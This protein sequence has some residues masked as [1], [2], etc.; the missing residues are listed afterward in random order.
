[1]TPPRTPARR[2]S[3]AALACTIAWC[4]AG[5]A[6]PQA[7]GPGP[8]PDETLPAAV[9]QA[10]LQAG[11]APDSLGAIAL[12]L[13]HAGR[14]WRFR[15][16]VPMQPGSAMKVVTAVVALDRLGVTHTGQ[17][18][19]LSGAPVVDGVLQG[20]LVLQGG[21]DPDLGIATLWQLMRELRDQ[22]ITSIAGDLVLDRQRYRPARLDLVEPPF[23][24]RPESWWNVV[25]DA[26]LLDLG[27]QTLELVADDSTLRARLKPAIQGVR[28]DTSAVRLTDTP[29]SAWQTDWQTPLRRDDAASGQGGQAGAVLVLQGGF[30]RRCT[31]RED[32]QA[33]ERTRY[34]GLAFGQLW[35]EMGGRWAGQVRDAEVPAP[36]SLRVLAQRRSRPWGEMLRMMVKTSDNTLARLLFLELGVKEMGAQPESSTLALAQGATQ[37]WFA[38]QRIDAQGLVVD[39]GSGLSRSESISAGTLAQT[40]AWAWRSRHAAD[41]LMS[42]PLVG[43]DGTMRNRLKDSPATGWARMKTGTL[44]NVTAL[45]GVAMDDQGR[46]WALV[47]IVNDEERSQ[48]GR[49]ALDALVDSLARGAFGAR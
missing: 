14:P 3:A 41:L 15:S 13:G 34:T 39:N 45:A 30:P 40:L 18:R 47:G 35:R 7:P 9:Q 1:M 26:L 23:D 49:A 19:L 38:E 4:L 17:T 24:A 8:L 5:C 48:E 37:R 46:P 32:L 36:A 20:D 10:L 33:V 31:R 29:C 16:Q 6:V 42:L 21:A 2:F 27:L 43:V 25:P 12:P 11:L 44:R 22:G 28:I